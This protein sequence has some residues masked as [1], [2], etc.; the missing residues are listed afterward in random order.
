M[1]I[2]QVVIWGHKLHSHTHSYIHNGFFIAFKKLGFKT[3]YFDD[4]DDVTNHDFSN[5]LFITE[6][7]VNKKI[8]LRQDC[9]YVTHYI[10]EGDYI[11]IPKE[12]IIILKVTLRDF[13]EKEQHLN[14]NYIELQYGQKYEYH[15]VD[16]GYNSLYMYWATD[17]LPEEIN[18]NMKN[19]DNIKNENEINF[20]GCMTNKWAELSYICNQYGIRFNNYGGTFNIYSNR[21]VSVKDNMG[22]I[23]KSIIAPALQD[24]EQISKQYIPCRIFKNISYGKMGI[25]NNKIVNELFDNKL[26]YDT[27]IHQ[28]FL[29]S[30]DFERINNKKEIIL[31]LMNHVKENHT[32]INR[33]NTI[34]KYIHEYTNFT[35]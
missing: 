18:E 9:L 33:S 12:N 32:Y 30:V 24:D 19:I 17:L 21:N 3:Y 34:I 27:N 1:K 25:T 13:V 35:I 4:N 14:L 20:I 6:H 29:K 5:S 7:Q 23:Q 11:G 10:D 15:A 2:N 16:N 28:L 26:I 8:P 31:E 22:L